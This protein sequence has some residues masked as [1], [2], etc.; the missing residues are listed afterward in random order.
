MTEHASTTPSSKNPVGRPQM[1]TPQEI[2]TI[3]ADLEKWIETQD[4]PTLVAF[5]SS[6][7]K[8]RVNKD[9]ISDHDEFSDLRKRSIEKQE[10]YLVKGATKNSLNPT[11]AIF[12]LKQPQH[13]YSDRSQLDARVETVQPILNGSSAD[14]LL[15]DDDD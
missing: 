13:G 1:Y 12:R 4:D 14:A 10:A 2:Q 5:T 8:Y 15:T 3:V 6:Y 7:T 11:M 9:Y